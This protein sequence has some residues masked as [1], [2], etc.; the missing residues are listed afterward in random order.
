MHPFP[1]DI[2]KVIPACTIFTALREKHLG[3]STLFFYNFKYSNPSSIL[4]LLQ[5][6]PLVFCSHISYQN[7]LT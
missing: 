2:S 5:N 3:K 7:L 4:I 6:H 1:D